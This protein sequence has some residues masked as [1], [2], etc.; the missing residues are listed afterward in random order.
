MTWQLGSGAFLGWALGANDAANVF[1]T[2]VA[3]RLVSYSTAVILLALFI[4]L[5]AA[6]EGAKCIATVNEV[7][8]LNGEMAFLVTL[9]AGVV[10]WIFSMLA[11]P[12]SSSQALIGAL[13]FIGLAGGNAQWGVLIKIGICWILTP[14]SAALLSVLLYLALGLLLRPLLTNLVWR[15]PVLRWLVIVAGCYGAYTLGS[16][17]VANVSGVYV[18][19]GLLTPRA[20]ALFGGLA[21]SLGVV[22]YSRKVM[23]TVG[24]DIVPLDAFSAF[25]NVLALA[26]SSHLFT[27]IGVPV[28]STQAVVGSVL[29]IGLLKDSSRINKKTVLT[30]ALGW[31]ATPLAGLLVCLILFNLYNL[32][33]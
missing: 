33:I 1:G 3:A 21:I 17:N 2:S 20:A 27:Q 32:F 25:I 9:S 15:T 26:I 24:R 13:L 6:L 4:I 10:M 19:A 11:L 31:L 5:G 23:M 14:V 8:Q 16:N 18:G 12:A 7:T 29:G 28:S 22:T 30:I